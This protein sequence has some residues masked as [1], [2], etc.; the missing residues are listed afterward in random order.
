MWKYLS[1][2][3]LVISLFFLI[4]FAYRI[5]AYKIDN[6]KLNN[7]LADLSRLNKETETVYSKLAIDLDNIETTNKELQ[8]IISKRNENIVSLTQANLLLK[9]KF[10]K[11]SN[12]RETV[13]TDSGDS[14][15][16]G[17]TKRIKVEFEHTEDLLNIKGY[18]LTN[19]AYAE[20]ALSWLKELNLNIVVAKNKD[21][22]YRVYIDSKNSDIVPT[23]I[24]LTVDSSLFDLHWYEK[25]G[26]GGGV[27]LTNDYNIIPYFQISYFFNVTNSFDLRPYVEYGYSYMSNRMNY[28]VGT[29]LVWYPFK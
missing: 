13:V 25:I 11:A 9:D 1:T 3:L 5:H 18:T 10:F 4:N 19:P 29:D 17:D 14:V 22:S 23:D 6:F 12:V 28:S 27:N 8:D 16:S 24:K 21:N 26:V 20:V 2:F 15:N 7:E